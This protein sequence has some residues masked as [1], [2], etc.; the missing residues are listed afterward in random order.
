MLQSGSGTVRKRTPGEIYRESAAPPGVN[1]LTHKHDGCKRFFWWCVIVA[2]V[3]YPAY[4][5]NKNFKK[6][7]SYPSSVI[8]IKD[9][10]NQ[11]PEISFP[12]VTL[13]A[14][15]IHSMRLIHESYDWLPHSVSEQI[16]DGDKNETGLGVEL[17]KPVDV[18]DGES[19]K[20]VQKPRMSQAEF[21]ELIDL[22]K[23]TDFDVFA[24]KTKS[25]L[26]IVGCKYLKKFDCEPQA[27]PKAWSLIHTPFGYCHTLSPAQVYVEMRDQYFA[28][29][30]QVEL[31]LISIHNDTDGV[32]GPFQHYSG[33][34]LFYSDARIES[35]SRFNSITVAPHDVP[36]ISFTQFHE[37]KL[38]EKYSD[39]YQEG[40][41][42]LNYYDYYAYEHCIRE[43]FGETILA[44]C[45]CVS[46]SYL[47]ETA[48]VIEFKRR[49]GIEV[50]RC[51]LYDQ[52]FCVSK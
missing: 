45:A 46:H 10:L 41:Y 19:D 48:Q 47:K 2:G 32:G 33:L 20:M 5:F 8:P 1:Y 4:N 6:Y 23:T 18:W 40:E 43:C 28:Y 51:T 36:I 38:G 25:Q 15:G 31:N 24:N 42:E 29:G 9:L 39:C 13:C 37:K 26:Q 7:N 11:A 3:V 12:K 44:K 49:Q 52:M 27:H 16:Y 30:R 21:D 50:R 14:N 22:M 34:T 35:L 17:M